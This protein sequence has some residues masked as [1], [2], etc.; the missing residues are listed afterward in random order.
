MA[1]LKRGLKTYESKRFGRAI[2]L[3]RMQ[4]QRLA[5]AEKLHDAV[6]GKLPLPPTPNPLQFPPLRKNKTAL[7]VRTLLFEFT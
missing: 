7:A 2:A 3:V 4:Q 1:A 5:T 6:L